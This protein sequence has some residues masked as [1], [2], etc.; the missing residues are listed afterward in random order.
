MQNKPGYA[1][2]HTTFLI[3][4]YKWAQWIKVLHCFRAQRLAREKNTLEIIGLICKLRRRWS[5]LNMTPEAYVIQLCT[6][7][8]YC[9]FMV[10]F[11]FCVH[12]WHYW[13]MGIYH[14]SIC[15]I[16]VIYHNFTH[17]GSKLLCYG[18]KLLLYFNL[19]KS[20]VKITTVNY[21]SILITM[22]SISEV[23]IFKYF[24]K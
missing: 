18:V 13:G 8:V 19:R 4:T 6:V 7:A 3:I 9:Y 1:D 24:W 11:L 21:C 22:V 20:R 16:N 2:I 10:L 15:I 12:Y 5:V 23:A 14:H 17:N